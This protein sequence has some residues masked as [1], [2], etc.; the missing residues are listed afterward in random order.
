MLTIRRTRQQPTLA[1][2][3]DRPPDQVSWFDLERV[4]ERDPEA[5]AGSGKGC[6]RRHGTSWRAV[7]ARREDL[8]WD[9]HPWDRARFLAIRDNFRAACD[10]RPGLGGA[11]VDLAAGAFGDYLAWSE[12]LHMQANNRGEPGAP[13]S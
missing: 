4:V 13:R 9:G 6:G 12:Q 3:R 2:I 7:T 8:D 11:L 1:R 5:M 10:P